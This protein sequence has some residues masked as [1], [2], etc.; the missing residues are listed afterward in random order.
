[1]NLFQDEISN[2]LIDLKFESGWV[3][4]L[5]P[6]LSSNVFID[7][8]NKVKRERENKII[9]PNEEDVF[10]IFRICPFKSIKVVV[11]G[12]DP[13][14]NG[15]ATGIAFACKKEL[16]PSLN[17]IITAIGYDTIYSGGNEGKLVLNKEEASKRMDLE[18]LVKQG[19]FLYN[20]ILTVVK[21][22]ALSHQGIGWLAFSNTVFKSLI[23]NKSTLSWM[24][25]GKVA[26]NTLPFN[27][28]SFHQVLKASHPVS[29]SYGGGIWNCSH[30]S[31]C[32]NYLKTKN[33]EEIKWL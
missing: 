11:I 7:I 15:N 1:M 28:P 5:S 25:W 13:Y 19:V 24:A 26:Q 31:E 3:N 4:A 29:A 30:F 22:N 23:V 14:F 16:S 2:L 10:K 32:N 6:Y 20:P 17:Q 9:Y 33:K 21:D 18:Y 12:Q 27:I 8:L